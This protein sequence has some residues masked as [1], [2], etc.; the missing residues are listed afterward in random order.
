MMNGTESEKIETDTE[1]DCEYV[2]AQYIEER[3][4]LVSVTGSTVATVSFIENLFLFAVL[5]AK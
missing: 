3:F 2:P 4:W 5:L 1:Y